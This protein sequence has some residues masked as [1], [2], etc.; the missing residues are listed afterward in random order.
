[1]PFGGMKATGVGPREQGVEVFGFYT[2]TK[3]VYIDYTGIRR[4]GK[5][6]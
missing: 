4:E 3:A 6:Y 1:M 5:L 2:E